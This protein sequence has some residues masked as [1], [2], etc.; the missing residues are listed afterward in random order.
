MFWFEISKTIRDKFE[1]ESEDM[2]NG[3]NGMIRSKFSSIFLILMLVFAGF[4]GILIVDDEDSIV[5]GK[6]LYVGG[7]GGGNYTYIQDAINA[8]STGDTIFVY[9]GTYV[10]NLT[11]MKTI[12]LIGEDRSNTTIKARS[13]INFSLTPLNIYASKVVIKDFTIKSN[14]WYTSELINFNT[15]KDSVLINCIIVSNKYRG[16]YLYQSSNITVKNNIF[17]CSGTYGIQ[18][19]NSNNNNILNNTFMDDYIHLSQSSHNV[20]ESNNLSGSSGTQYHHGISVLHSSQMNKIVNNNI[21]DWRGHGMNIFNSMHNNITNN[22]IYNNS[23]GSTSYSGILIQSAINTTISRNLIENNGYAGIYSKHSTKN[24]VTFNIICN[25]S[26]GF[27]YFTN[28]VGNKVYLNDFMSNTKHFGGGQNYRTWNSTNPIKY[29]FNNS[30]FTRYMGNYWDDYAGSDV[31]GDGIGD[32]IYNLSVANTS[33]KDLFPLMK[34]IK[35]YDITEFSIKQGMLSTTFNSKNITVSIDVRQANISGLLKGDINGTITITNLKFIILNSSFFSGKGFFIANYTATIN[36]VEFSGHWR[37]MLYNKT[38]ERKIYLKGALSGGIKGITDDYLIESVNG[39]GNYD[40]Y[41]SSWTLNYLGPDLIYAEITVNSTVSYQNSSNF[42]SEIYILQ[43]YFNGTST[44]YFYGTSSIVLTHIRINNVTN[45]YYGQ[46]FSSFAFIST[47]GTGSGW[48]Y[49]KIVTNQIVKLTGF[50]T[51]PIWGL[52]FGTLDETGGTKTLSL[53]IMRIDIGLPPRAIVDI[54]LWCRTLASPGQTLHYILKYSNSGVLTAYNIKLVVELPKSTT[55]YISNSVYGFGNTSKPGSGIYNSTTHSVT[56]KLN[57]PAKSRNYVSVKFKIKWGLSWGTKL[58]CKAYAIDYIKNKTLD[59]DKF[60]TIIRQAWDP[61]EKFG[62]EGNVTVGQMLNYTIEYENVGAG[63]AY[64]VFFTDELSSHL[65]ESTLA[66]GPVIST[67]NGSV[68]APPGIYDPGTRTVIWFVGEV[69]PKEGGY[70]NISIKVHDDLPYGTEILNYGTIY[71]PSVP[72][73]TRTNAIVSIARTIKNPIAVAGSN[74]VV[75]TQQTIKFDGAGSYDLDGWL[76]NY[77][78]DFGDGEI[79]YGLDTSHSYADDGNYTVNLTVRDDMGLVGHHEINVQV[80]NRI[81][82][83]KITA[84][85]TDVNT[86]ELVSFDA[87]TSTDV[88]GTILNYHFDFGDGSNSGWIQSQTISHQFTDGTVTYTVK[89][90]VKDDDGRVSTNLAEV[91][92]NVNNRAPIGEVSA[93]PQEAYTYEDILCTAELSSDTDGEISWYNFD[94]GDGESSG[95]IATP[96]STHQY[97]DGTMKYNIGVQVKDDDGV[98]SSN[99]P[100]FEILIKNRKPVPS[101]KVVDTDVHVFSEVSFDASE[102]YDMDGAELEFYFDFGDGNNSNWVANPIVKHTYTVGPQD[103][104]ITLKVKDSD[105]EINSTELKLEVKNRVPIANAG[106]DQVV[107]EDESITFDGSQSYDPEGNKI[108]YNWAFGDGTSS[109]WLTSSKSTHFYKS[110]GIYTVTLTVS[111]GSLTGSDSAKVEVMEIFS[112]EPKILDSFPTNIELNEDFG[113]WSQELTAYESH[114]NLEVSS[115]DLKWYVTDNNG[116]I[117]EVSGDNST[118]AEADTFEFTSIPNKNGLEVLVFHLYDPQ[119]VEVT[120]YQSVKINPVNDPPD[121]L[122]LPRV[123]VDEDVELIMD[124][125]EYVQ[126]IDNDISELTFVTDYISNI[127][128]KE[129]SLI[130]EFEDDGEYT[131]KVKVYDGEFTDEANLLVT[132]LHVDEVNLTDFDEDGMPNLWE[133]YYNLNPNDPTDAEIDLDSDQLSNLYEYNLGTD[134]TLYDTDY[135]GLNDQLDPYPTDPNKPSIGET[136]DEP[137]ENIYVMAGIIIVILIVIF[138][139]VSYLLMVKNRNKRVVKP[140]DDDELIRT[141]RDNIIS[142]ESDFKQD[143]LDSELWDTLESK[144][145]NG[146]ISEETYRL[147]EQELSK[148]N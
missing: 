37:G 31:N 115:D 56:W 90:K 52:V 94:F 27:Y 1:M 13:I 128:I 141:V 82:Q 68:L 142:G 73:V 33:E 75:N 59:T 76:V 47:W 61:N 41:N 79:G 112:G 38:G 5:S 136:P 32:S 98:V 55:I 87:S 83:A 104:T 134:P 133:E 139:G 4:I 101:L 109:G 65:D 125:E 64:G 22:K 140:F 70:G 120:V 50:F 88:D 48:T 23:R 49:D 96:S 145:Q 132:V 102:S 124:I 20:I 25:N 42:T 17:S 77:T 71:F 43:A 85:S 106:P 15:A 24:L 39:S 138:L 147:M 69:G 46:G 108:T 86:N 121:I 40:L 11:I 127:E 21:Y 19:Y 148:R 144:Y 12:N 126:D 91:K 58:I 103:Y 72:Q 28:Y 18:I 116:D 95:W 89:L 3:D 30:G 6:T 107:I 146:E 29:I 117:F 36:S 9:N 45:E 129:T 51:K 54:E 66:I 80:L 135:D 122:P 143:M 2:L 123:T 119:G 67:N 62:P 130:I 105:G 84:N 100:T 7:T 74:L 53:S 26:H 34:P 35:Y 97:T 60:K 10:E 57:I 131:I 8:S 81:P 44:G 63:I 114:S 14:S 93:T 16:I 99:L 92:I 137:S 111:D 113:T 118:G 110:A 78:W